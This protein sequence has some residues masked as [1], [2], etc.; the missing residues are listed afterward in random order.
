MSHSHYQGGDPA[1]YPQASCGFD[2]DAVDESIARHD[3]ELRQRTGL[4][5]PVEVILAIPEQM[6]TSDALLKYIAWVIDGNNYLLRIDV[7]IAAIGI[8]LYQG[9][10]Y[11]EMARKHG[12]SKQAF[13]K[14]VLK[15][16][17]DFQLPITR[18]QKSPAARESYK[19]HQLERN[20][21]LRQTTAATKERTELVW[22]NSLGKAPRVL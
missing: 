10:S 15:F 11:T 6:R 4:G 1:G 18:A 12:I 8:P 19:R 7:S 20:E 5:V 14:Q 3:R 22:Q 17:K 2:F 9:I 21:R 13:D 16:Q